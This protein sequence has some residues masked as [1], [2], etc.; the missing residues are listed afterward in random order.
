MSSANKSFGA[1]SPPL[2]ATG[3]DQPMGMSSVGGD[4]AQAVPD[5][6]QRAG[7]VSPLYGTVQCAEMS[8][9]H[10]VLQN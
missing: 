6:E 3:E 9:V 8:Y 4:K 10:S 5:T 1:Q 2:E 7:E